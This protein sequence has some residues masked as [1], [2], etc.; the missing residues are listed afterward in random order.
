MQH[1]AQFRALRSSQGFSLIEVLVAL[2]V[3]SVALLGSV[4]MQLRALQLGQSSQWRDQAVVLAADLAERLEAN[5]AAAILDRAYAILETSTA[6]SFSPS[7]S[8][9]CSRTEVAVR[10]LYEW[11]TLVYATL[12]QSTWAVQQ[13][14]G[15]NPGTYEIRLKWADAHGD[16][17]ASH[18]AAAVVSSYVSTRTVYRP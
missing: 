6:P 10:D 1:L 15:G 12:P 13:T 18:N 9:T 4:A 7:C 11:Q 14:G 17:T 8:S 2:V 3:I 5:K 16:P